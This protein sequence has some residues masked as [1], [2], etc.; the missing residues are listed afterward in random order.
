MLQDLRAALEH[1]KRARKFVRRDLN[2]FRYP[3]VFE[4][5]DHL[6]TDLSVMIKDRARFPKA[7]SPKDN[8][9]ET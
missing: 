6:I 8:G 2:R 7:H 3:M 1:I 5:M 9:H 4:D